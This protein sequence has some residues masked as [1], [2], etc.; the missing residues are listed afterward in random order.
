MSAETLALARRFPGD[1][2]WGVATSAYQIEG[3]AHDGGR[4]DSIW[5]EFCRQP[6]TIKDGNNGS[7]ACDHY[8]RVDEDVALMAT[9][10][11]RA[12][13]FSIAWPRVQPLGE[14]AWNEAGFAFYAVIA[15]LCAA[16]SFSLAASVRASI[17]SGKPASATRSHS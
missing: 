8:H 11:V 13:R 2:V 6:G 10:N 9:L 14:G 7:R 15:V 3:A 5:D 1:F 4:G 16:L 17:D 12:Y